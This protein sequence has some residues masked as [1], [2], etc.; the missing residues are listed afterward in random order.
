MLKIIHNQTRTKTKMAYVLLKP[1]GG[2]VSLSL[3]VVQHIY[4][5]LLLIKQKEQKEQEEHKEHENKFCDTLWVIKNC[6]PKWEDE[7]LALQRSRLYFT[8][9]ANEN[10]KKKIR[11]FLKKTKNS[12]E[13]AHAVWSDPHH[14]NSFAILV[15]QIDV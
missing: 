3:D 5:Q 10:Y 12:Y 1:I 13:V 14:R 15:P 11:I 8:F 6:L 2:D 4:T 9:D 7:E